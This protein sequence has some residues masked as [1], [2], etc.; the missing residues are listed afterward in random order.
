[1]FDS[2]VK[3][4]KLSVE[5]RYWED[6]SLNNIEL[7]DEMYFPG[8]NGKILELII[9]VKTGE[10]LNWPLGNIA[11]IHFKVCDA[12]TYYLLDENGFVLY[13]RE[14]N[15]VPSGLCHGDSGFGDYIIFSVNSDGF[16]ENYIEKISKNDWVEVDD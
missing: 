10:V 1:M 9:D 16:I 12:G 14:D 6:G 11:S 5:P 13:T 15:Y 8:K 4:I 2:N 7:D 3:F